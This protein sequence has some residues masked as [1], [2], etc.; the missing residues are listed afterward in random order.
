MS[1]PFYVS[2]FDLIECGRTYRRRVATTRFAV[3][4][5]AMADAV[6][7]RHQSQGELLGVRK[8]LIQQLS[9]LEWNQGYRFLPIRCKLSSCV[10]S[11]SSQYLLLP[12]SIIA[13]TLLYR[14]SL[15]ESV[16][17]LR[18]ILMREFAQGLEWACS[19]IERVGNLRS[20]PEIPRIPVEEVSKLVNP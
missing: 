5:V 17:G 16:T 13:T 20:L 1:F 2:S 9:N 15:D 6:V 4:V 8:C 14:E 12:D 3:P 18:G 11:Q 7:R 19:A 10:S